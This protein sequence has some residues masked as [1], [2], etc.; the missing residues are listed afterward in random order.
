M[1]ILFTL[2]SLAGVLMKCLFVR[3]CPKLHCRDGEWVTRKIAR[4]KRGVLRSG[5][6]FQP[7]LCSFDI[8]PKEELAM[9][10]ESH[11]LKTIAILGLSVYSS[12]S[13]LNYLPQM[14]CIT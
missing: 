10:K 14:K 5:W 7:P 8:S 13:L 2:L 4:I 3:P 12:P 9:A 6:V 1:V 11:S